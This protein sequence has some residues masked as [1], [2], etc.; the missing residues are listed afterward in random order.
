[1]TKPVLLQLERC[2]ASLHALKRCMKG[3]KWHKLGECSQGIGAEMESLRLLLIDDADLNDDMIDQINYL[4]IQFRRVQRQLSM[5]M[6]AV[7]ADVQTLQ[8][9]IA[10]ADAAKALLIKL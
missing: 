2:H 7:D 3:R 9:G 4:D 10:Q 8:R 1:M 6:E 5:H